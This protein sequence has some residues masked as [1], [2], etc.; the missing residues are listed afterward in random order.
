MSLYVGAN[1]ETCKVCTSARETEKKNT[2]STP[3]STVSPGKLTVDQLVKKFSIFYGT[4]K[5]ITVFTEPATGRCPK[6][7][8]SN[9]RHTKLPTDNCFTV[10]TEKDVEGGDRGLF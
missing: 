7:E 2:G 6:P 8:E 10:E 9:Q 3:W 5:F 4:R 1:I